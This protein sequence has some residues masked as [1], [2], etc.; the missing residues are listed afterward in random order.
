MGKL[1]VAA[2]SGG[3]STDVFPYRPAFGTSGDPVILWTNYFKLQVKPQPL[4][5]Y[6]LQVHYVPAEEDSATPK[7][8]IGAKG[9]KREKKAG[10]RKL[11][12]IVQDAVRKT[13]SS[14]TY[15]TEYKG[16][17]ISLGD[18]ELPS[19]PIRVEYTEPG[20]NRVETWAVTFDG[21]TSIRLDALMNY[22]G[23]MIDPAG[24]TNFPK[25]A[26]EIDALN[27]ILGHTARTNP[28]AVTVGRSRFFKAAGDHVEHAKGVALETSLVSI[29][30]GYFQSVRPAT[31]QLLLNVNVTAGVFRR[32][33]NLA[34]LF[35][36]LGL[37]QM[38]RLGGM[39]EGES[40]AY[41]RDL[42]A[43]QKLLKRSR[44]QLEVLA[45]T[46][47]DTQYQ[48]KVIRGLATAEDV[49][50][51]NKNEWPLFQYKTFGFG[52]PNS[53]KFFLAEPGTGQPRVTGLKY[54]THC[55]VADY[56]KAS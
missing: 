13:G 2:S 6:A 50:T 20:R 39:S 46:R 32:S 21:P 34:E 28:N 25:F 19:N 14:S 42:R 29:L 27:V 48:D 16:Q 49:S 38:G 8:T 37:N 24:D 26:P 33:V 45:A 3:T 17:V 11:H 47:G 23:S 51:A 5:M 7:P 15:A 18:L 54:N 31:G 55:L 53:T 12:Q 4:S 44:I 40:R 10:G 22:L 56:Y 1:S 43:V 41:Q 30:R 9:P 35:C 36:R 52:G